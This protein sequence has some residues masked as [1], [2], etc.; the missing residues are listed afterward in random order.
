LFVL[1]GCQIRGR[2]GILSSSPFVRIR[3]SSP[4]ERMKLNCHDFKNP[5]NSSWQATQ[6]SL[7]EL[8]GSSYSRITLLSV[9]P[10]VPKAP[11]IARNELGHEFT[12]EGPGSRR[13]E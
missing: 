8:S 5:G 6:S 7:F 10:P 13:Y 4:G 9:R 12:S 3:E 2:R 11:E 1:R